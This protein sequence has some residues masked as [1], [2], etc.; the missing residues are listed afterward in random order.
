MF[1]PLERPLQILAA[2]LW[3]TLVGFGDI[4]GIGLSVYLLLYTRYWPLMGLYFVWIFW[5]WNIGETGGRR[6]E[7]VRN[8]HIWRLLCGYFSSRL[9]KTADLPPS[10]NYLFAVYPH[11][12]FCAG[13]F[14][15]FGSNATNFSATFPG[16]QSSLLTL[17][18]HY[19]FPFVREIFLALGAISCSEKSITRTLTQNQN[20]GK[21]LCLIV[22]G[23]REILKTKP[24]SY[25]IILKDRKGFVKLAIRTGTPLVP[26][27]IFGETDIY[28]TLSPQPGTWLHWIQGY[29]QRLF[30]IP[31]FLPLGQFG[32]LPRRTPLT[33]VIG[34]PIRVPKVAEPTRDMI[35]EY[36]AKF[37]HAL[38]QLFEDHK[39][40]YVASP[41]KARLVI[42]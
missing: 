10:S 37:T 6:S 25:E 35:D 7:S 11:G 5:D 42:H 26:V 29:T 1:G 21:V 40:K 9:V 24:G 41:G 2:A 3:V 30:S 19:W 8:W 34:A 4:L 38:Q 28:D 15:N 17:R 16:L 23:T 32:L 22:G 20:G 18:F 39:K 33:T 31:L 13:G 12:I 36:H 27:F 14:C